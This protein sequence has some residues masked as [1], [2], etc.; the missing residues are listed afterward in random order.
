MATTQHRRGDREVHRLDIRAAVIAPAMQARLRDW[1]QRLMIPSDHRK[2]VA[3]DVTMEALRSADTYDPAIAR[4]ERWFN[5]IAVNVAADWHYRAQRRL[6]ELQGD[7]PEIEAEG[8]LPDIALAAEQDR[9]A[10]LDA[11][12]LVPLK[13]GAIVAAH[14]LHGIPMSEV[15]ERFDVPEST[16]YKWRARGLALLAD[17]L[18]KLRG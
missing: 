9:M 17:A 13:L 5:R 14:D 16:A 2:D 7:L 15:A 4:P 6:E 8:I 11:L 3:Q 10:L 1:L 18:R 12:A